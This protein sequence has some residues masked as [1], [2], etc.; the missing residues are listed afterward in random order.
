MQ[1]GGF[2]GSTSPRSPAREGFRPC[3][4][5]PLATLSPTGGG[6]RPV[7]ILQ[8]AGAAFFLIFNLHTLPFLF[9]GVMMG[10]S[11]GILP[12][13]GGVAGTALLLPFTY[14]MDT[15]T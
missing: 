1:V 2:A 6:R 4:S 5:C 3:G 12:G 10:L 11:L 13:I 9:L 8:S 15:P 7:D 14:G